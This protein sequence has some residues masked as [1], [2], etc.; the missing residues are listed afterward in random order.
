VSYRDFERGV[1]ALDEVNAIKRTTHKHVMIFLIEIIRFDQGDLALNVEVQLKFDNEFSS[2]LS[3]ISPKNNNNNKK[4]IIIIIF[5]RSTTTTNS[6]RQP[7]APRP[8]PR[9][10]QP[11]IHSSMCVFGGLLNAV[12]FR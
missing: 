10:K 11:S 4:T 5:V 9:R 6:W 7:T 12:C 1:A 3:S 8:M 2:L